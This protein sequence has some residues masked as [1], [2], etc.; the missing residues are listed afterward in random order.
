MRN[1]ESALK[2]IRRYP[3]EQGIANMR[4]DMG[5]PAFAGA[6][7]PHRITGERRDESFRVMFEQAV[8]ETSKAHNRTRQ[9]RKH[10]T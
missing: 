3:Q 10:L 6:H 7:G 1:L 9:I 5:S 2:T 4:T 8:L